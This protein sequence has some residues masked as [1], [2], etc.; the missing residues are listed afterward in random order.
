MAKSAKKKILPSLGDFRPLPNKNVQISD[1]CNPLLFP[2]DSESLKI[3]DIPLREV[4]AKRCLNG[5]SKVNT[6][7]DRWTDRRTDRQTDIS[8]YRKHRPIGPMLWKYALFGLKDF[9]LEIM[10][11]FLYCKMLSNNLDES[12]RQLSHSQTSPGKSS[13]Q[14]AFG[15]SLCN[16]LPYCHPSEQP[17]INKLAQNFDSFG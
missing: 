11:E 10:L 15:N 14:D 13:C 3:L 4:G 17:Y 16:A 8:T 2:K 6:W 12:V 1:H 5:T 7:T 9:S